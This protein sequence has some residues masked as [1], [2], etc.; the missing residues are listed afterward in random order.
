MDPGWN[1]ATEDQAFCRILRRGRTQSTALT[2][3]VVKN[4]IDTAMMAMKERKKIEIDS[5]MD[6]SKRTAEISIYDMMRLFG[7]IAEDDQGRPFIFP[8]LDE[9]EP[10]HLRLANVDDEDEEQFIGNEE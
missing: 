6:D 3:L 1:A 7:N 9:M 4:S 10:E 5:V 2:R 8:T